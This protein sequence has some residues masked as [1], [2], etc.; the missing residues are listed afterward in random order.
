MVR[1]RLGLDWAAG[2]LTVMSIYW[3]VIPYLIESMMVRGMLGLFLSCIG[4]FICFWKGGRSPAIK[5]LEQMQTDEFRAQQVQA[6]HDQIQTIRE[7][8]LEV[9]QKQKSYREDTIQHVQA[10]SETLNRS[11]LSLAS[12]QPAQAAAATVA[13]TAMQ[14]D[15]FLQGKAVTDSQTN[16]NPA[17]VVTELQAQSTTLVA[18]PLAT[19]VAPLAP[20]G[21][22]VTT[23]AAAAVTDTTN[24]GIDTKTNAAPTLDL[25]QASLGHS[26]LFMDD[27]KEPEHA[28]TVAKSILDLV[29]NMARLL[30]KHHVI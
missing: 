30:P 5:K 13:A 6:Y 22:A 1:H 12:Q 14:K 9:L 15:D 27:S 8:A 16:L 2:W 24:V 21:A 17:F 20:S 25:S 11:L 3:P 10:L 19:T 18:A 29:C 4:G 23:T 7:R 26:S 28:I